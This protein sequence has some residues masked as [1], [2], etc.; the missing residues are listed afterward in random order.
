MTEAQRATIEAICGAAVENIE[1]FPG[2]DISGASAVRL[3]DGRKLVA[4]YGPVVAVEAGMLRA[5]Q[6]ASTPSPRVIGCRDDVMVIEHLVA[7][8]AF[9][10]AWDSLAEALFGL[11]ELTSES[12]GWHED[13]A[14][15]HVQVENSP[16]D[17]WSR[18]WAE[19]RLACHVPHL[20]PSLG[21]RIEKLA[22]A[23]EEI[24]PA[25][26]VATFVHGDL[27]GGNV[28]ASGNRITGLIDPCACWGD[29][30]V[31]AASL[32]VFDHPPESFF[33]ALDLAAGWRGRQPVYRLW[34]WLLHVRL[35]GDSYRP[36]VERE[37]DTLGF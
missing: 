24:I 18:F 16:C 34:M 9:Q 25:K 7:D 13:Y 35:F 31:D 1:R 33:A 12:Y 32:T 36:A 6:A 10:N 20:E 3:A 11:G 37:L 28:L 15:R 21:R 2:G 29:R 26:P 17:S 27:W 22:D 8:G 14:L 19:R 23:L 30:E 5:M 4:K